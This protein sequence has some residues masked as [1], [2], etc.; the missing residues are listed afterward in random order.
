MGYDKPDNWKNLI[1]AQHWFLCFHHG[2]NVGA[3][4]TIVTNGSCI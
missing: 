4:L 3:G 1:S 2:T